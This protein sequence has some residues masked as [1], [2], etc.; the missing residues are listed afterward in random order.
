MFTCLAVCPLLE[1]LYRL[2]DVVGGRCKKSSVTG[3]RTLVPR[4]TGGNTGH[5]GYGYEVMELADKSLQS[6]I[7][8][9]VGKLYLHTMTEESVVRV[10]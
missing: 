3:N 5:S 10:R 8:V 6:Y 9:R 4:V 1:V 7:G 2:S